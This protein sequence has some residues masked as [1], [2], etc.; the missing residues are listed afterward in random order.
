MKLSTRARYGIHAMFELATRYG[1]GPQ[2][3]KSIAESQSIPEQ[4]LEQLMG[5]LR[6]E[7]LVESA[8][9]AATCSA[10]RPVRSRWAS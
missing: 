5:L 10:G 9:R 8:R 2:P 3:L 7:G 6:R 1:Q 4:Y